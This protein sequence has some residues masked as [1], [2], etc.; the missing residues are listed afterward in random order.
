MTPLLIPSIAGAIAFGGSHASLHDGVG[1]RQWKPSG[2]PASSDYRLAFGQGT[3]DLRDA[4]VP[5]TAQ[6][7]N[8]TMGAGQV[9]IIAPKTMN[10][11]V[12]ANIHIGQLVVD[13]NQDDAHGGYGL[14]RT[15]DPLPAASGIPITVNVHLADG[16]ITVDHR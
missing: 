10:L 1:D 9:R 8:V 15:V 3:L 4:A 7:I 11:T 16:Q 5:A 14:S 13:G 12:V 6:T 2:V